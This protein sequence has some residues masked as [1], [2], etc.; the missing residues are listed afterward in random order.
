[1]FLGAVYAHRNEDVVNL[2]SRCLV[3]EKQSSS[4][5]QDD[6]QPRPPPEEIR[7][8]DAAAE[9][10]TVE[11]EMDS[12]S[13]VCDASSKKRKSDHSSLLAMLIGIDEGELNKL[14]LA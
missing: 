7:E 1:M 2:R 10:K 4:R 6:E 9:A 14:M 5:E 3:S 8:S 11:T 12:S 13:R